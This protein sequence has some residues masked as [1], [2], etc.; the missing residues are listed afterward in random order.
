[1][2]SLGVRIRR[3]VS[4]FIELNHHIVEHKLNEAN[5]DECLRKEGKGSMDERIV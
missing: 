3:L 4:M 1:M 5:R 2:A